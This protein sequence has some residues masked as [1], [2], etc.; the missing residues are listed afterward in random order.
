MRYTFLLFWFFFLGVNALSA[1]ITQVSVTGVVTPPVSPYF[2]DYLNNSSKLI[3]T[4]M[5]TGSPGAKGR[6]YFRGSITGDNGVA[7]EVKSDY[8]PSNWIDLTAGVPKV[9]RVRDFE[10]MFTRN[11]TRF[12]GITPQE[13]FNG[14]GLPEG[15]YNACLDV[16]DYGTD[17]KLTPDNP[18]NCLPPIILRY[19]DPPQLITPVCNAQ[20]NANPVQNVVFNWSI[21]P[22]VTPQVEY[23]V[24]I[25]P[26]LNGQNPFD[27]I[28]T[29][30]TPAFFERTVKTTS[31]LYGP[32]FLKLE[33]G[34]RYA[35]RIKA[36]DPQKKLLFKNGGE[37][38][39][40]TFTYLPGVNDRV[41]L[42]SPANNGFSVFNGEH[43]FRYQLPVGLKP[44]GVQMTLV[45]LKEFQKAGAAIHAN[46]N[47]YPDKGFQPFTDAVFRMKQSLPPGDYAWKVTVQLNKQNP[48]ATLESDVW[49]FKVQP[50]MDAKDKI[51]SFLMA[52]YDITVEEISTQN[53]DEFKGKGFLYFK[54]G[55][56]KVP[57]VFMNLKLRHFGM[58][59]GLPTQ[60]RVVHG[61]LTATLPVPETL[62]VPCSDQVKGTMQVNGTGIELDVY[63]LA[64]NFNDLKNHYVLGEYDKALPEKAML[65]ATMVW[66]TPFTRTVTSQQFKPNGLGGS[67]VT[68]TQTVAVEIASQKGQLD[69]IDA[70]Q[71]FLSGN[72]PF[73][74]E[75]VLELDAPEGIITF[76]K[77]S[78]LTIVDKKAS[79][80]LNGNYKIPIKEKTY[81]VATNSYKAEMD[82][83]E[84]NNQ[85]T[86]YLSATIS[87]G[88]KTHALSKDKSLSLIIDAVKI[89]L[90]S[91][92][93]DAKCNGFSGLGIYIPYARLEY[94][95]GDQVIVLT[96]E[97]CVT[98]FGNGYRI[99]EKKGKVGDFSMEGFST[100]DNGFYCFVEY[101]KLLD[102]GI[103][104]NILVPY[105]NATFPYELWVTANGSQGGNIDFS[106]KE[107]TV[108]NKAP[109]KVTFTPTYGVVKNG[110]AR[111]DGKFSFYNTEGRHLQLKNIEIKK[112]SIKPDGTATN[113]GGWYILPSQVQGKY[114]GYVYKASAIKLAPTSDGKQSIKVTGQ[115]VL[116][117]ESL[118][119]KDALAVQYVYQPRN[120]SL[121]YHEEGTLAT[122]DND[123]AW[124][125][126]DHP[127]PL[128]ED[129]DVDI[130]SN[131]IRTAH[132]GP[133]GNFEIYVA[134]KDNDPVYGTGFIGSGKSKMTTPMP[135][136]ASVYLAVGK[137][138]DFNYWFVEA[139]MQNFP[140][141]PTGVLDV[142]IYG[143]KGRVYYHMDHAPGS[144][145]INAN[146]YI[147]SSKV[148][149]GLFALVDLQTM[150][151]NG[152]VLW[153][154]L[155]MEVTT[156][157]SW[158]LN[159]IALRG[160]AQ[161]LSSGVGQTDGKVQGYAD[162]TMGFSPDKYF[163][164]LV[165]VESDIYNVINV[166]GDLN[167]NFDKT[168]FMI[169]LGTPE[170]P[171]SAYLIPADK[172]V[173]AYFVISKYT[174]NVEVIFG[175]KGDIFS[176]GVNK[177]KC[178]GC[179]YLAECCFIA[180]ANV[181]VNGS[182]DGKVIFPDFQMQGGVSLNATASVCASACGI[183]FCPGV[184]A[185]VTGQFALPSP[186]CVGGSFELKP[187][188]PLP[189]IGFSARYHSE[190]GVEFG[191]GH[192]Y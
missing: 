8:K 76:G 93:S 50:T 42:I 45:Q 91:Q 177:R 11:G 170:T 153:G 9:L 60:W 25:V 138:S 123:A 190:H 146:D 53:N 166:K 12:T 96:T 162:F 103:V 192:C 137:K 23:L 127:V 185:T 156:T 1:Q 125:V 24:K 159:K 134:Y 106:T 38:E 80:L 148:G 89:R 157:P 100:Q 86:L 149:L 174:S 122:V 75:Y 108:Y 116:E 98:N 144:T 13:L 32:Q 109:N 155:S 88:K 55:G 72:L 184:S 73:D 173:T 29:L 152:G 105:I 46:T 119:N 140:P 133:L 145:S 2:S 118:S 18:L 64:H 54:K 85:N 61:R 19:I 141:I 66:K 130:S 90:Y 35:I 52:G 37:S 92:L 113:A 74:K 160:E 39:V 48:N 22:G 20:V 186:F 111:V 99:N 168:G 62:T 131:S 139:A 132:N 102:F 126:D 169:G 94:K 167:M 124:V 15:N 179:C 143:F 87:G 17:K 67:M 14:G 21:S 6:V 110:L 176:I 36:Y 77:T 68:T 47:I 95:N 182:I 58:T 136:D 51:K 82:L 83:F 178:Y 147:P 107:F 181:N 59:N 121:N 115:V 34:M 135:L 40:C 28:N 69:I 101:G 142:G 154:P 165:H 10:T 41:T 97:K 26:V 5:P 78:S 172:T 171:V 114:N 183:G 84:F 191:V 4:L 70:Q 27:A 175:A 120:P 158:G 57:V 44:A 164:G 30:T 151:S 3:I 71:L 128:M 7:L 79:V 129:N 81:N 117:K 150:G 65:T 63:Q 161:I 188:S 189:D 187:R 180:S 112:L 56:Q 31:L 49:T 104:G 33:L 43:A 163:K 16:Y